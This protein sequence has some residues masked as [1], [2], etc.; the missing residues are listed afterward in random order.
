MNIPLRRPRQIIQEKNCLCDIDLM[1][2]N[3]NNNNDSDN[4]DI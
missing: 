1:A 2:N 4:N 3:N